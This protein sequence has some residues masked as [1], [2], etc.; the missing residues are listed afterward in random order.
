M[1]PTHHSHPQ[2]AAVLLQHPH[3]HLCHSH[4]Q[5]IVCVH[6]LTALNKFTW[7]KVSIPCIIEEPCH[8][9]GTVAGSPLQQD[10]SD[11]PSIPDTDPRDEQ[12]S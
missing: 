10:N 2:T 3:T 8:P 6:G 1:W 9:Q 7:D 4:S 5:S 12:F 11:N